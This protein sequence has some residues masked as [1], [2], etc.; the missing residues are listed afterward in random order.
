MV[1]IVCWNIVRHRIVRRRLTCISEDAEKL[2]HAR[3]T[4]LVGLTMRK[5]ILAGRVYR[6]FAS[7]FEPTRIFS[8]S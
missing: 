8:F 6:L 5:L 4:L 1:G 2:R 7:Q 3:I